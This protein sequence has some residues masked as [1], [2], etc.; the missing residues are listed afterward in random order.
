M[1]LDHTMVRTKYQLFLEPLFTTCVK[2]EMKYNEA[3]VLS[4]VVL[5]FQVSGFLV[6]K[7][8]VRLFKQKS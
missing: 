4:F 1:V 6:I 7:T 3:N 8:D 2:S 5:G